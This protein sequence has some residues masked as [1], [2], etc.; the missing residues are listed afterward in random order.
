MLFYRAAG[1]KIL[2][3]ET[4]IEA[5]RRLF[6]TILSL[7]DMEECAAFFEDLLTY[8]EVDSMSQ[9]LRAAELMFKGKTYD[10]ITEETNISS[11]TLSRISK[12]LH[13]GEGYKKVLSKTCDKKA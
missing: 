3:K 8:N 11:A 10:Q 12:C 7:E 13:Y 2:L 1:R 4:F 6:E 5:H 9:R